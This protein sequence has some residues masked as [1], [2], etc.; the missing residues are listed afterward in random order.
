MTKVEAHISKLGLKV[1]DQVTG[2]EGV[3]TGVTFDLYGCIQCIVNPGLDKEGKP[4]DTLWFDIARLHPL[5]PTP[6]MPVPDFVSG[7]V[8][9]RLKGP[10]EKPAYSKS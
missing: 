5:S 4:R 2:L 6:V 9:E 7:S 3:I 8:A 1:R 10:G